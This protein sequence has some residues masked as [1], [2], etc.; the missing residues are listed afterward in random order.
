MASA[1]A[2]QARRKLPREQ[3]AQHCSTEAC[4]GSITAGT[5][6]E[7][8][9][10]VSEKLLGKKTISSSSQ[11]PWMGENHASLCSDSR[12]AVAN[13]R[14]YFSI[15][16]IPIF[17]VYRCLVSPSA[18]PA[19]ITGHP[20]THTHRIIKSSSDDNKVNKAVAYLR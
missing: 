16:W 12:C 18:S 8:K 1:P 20:H 9:A 10:K 13:A 5:T 15:L 7:R 3:T 19:Y 14:L 4:N 17:G 6:S 11:R 2:R